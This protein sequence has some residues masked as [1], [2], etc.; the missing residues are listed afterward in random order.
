LIA[1]IVL[2]GLAG[3]AMAV[4]AGQSLLAGAVLGAVGGVA[5]TYAGHYLRV[6]LVK[7]LKV[8]DVVIALL[9]DVVAIGGSVLVAFRF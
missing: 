9:E 4:S 6:S 1:R 5:G 3:A 8:P 7:A 2:G